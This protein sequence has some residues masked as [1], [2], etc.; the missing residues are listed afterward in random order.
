MKYF[1]FY[2]KTILNTQQDSAIIISYFI[3][4]ILI[5]Q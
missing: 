1:N 2:N 4:F 3:E 5:K